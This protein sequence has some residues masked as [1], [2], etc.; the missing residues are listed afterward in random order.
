MGTVP[1]DLYRIQHLNE[2]NI[3]KKIAGRKFFETYLV[4]S[5]NPIRRQRTC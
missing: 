1:S 2:K 3:K 4:A 5:L